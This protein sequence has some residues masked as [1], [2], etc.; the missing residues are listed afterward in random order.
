MSEI[1]LVS[2]S[3]PKATGWGGG[4]H[5]PRRPQD[6]VGG[7]QIISIFQKSEVKSHYDLFLSLTNCI[8]VSS[9][10]T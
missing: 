8:T 7:L 9:V 5:A 3:P 1:I 6:N 4:Q 10:H 2:G